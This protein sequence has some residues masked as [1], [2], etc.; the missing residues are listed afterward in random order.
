MVACCLAYIGIVENARDL[1]KKTNLPLSI[2]HYLNNMA[3]LTNQW[4]SKNYKDPD[5]QRIYLKDIDCPTL[6]HD[7]LSNII[8]PALFYL[9]ESTGDHGGPGAVEEPKP[10][11]PGIRRGRAIAHAGDL[12]SSLPP[13]M[14]AENMMC[15]IGH[16]GTYTPAHREMCASLGHNIMV[17]TSTGAMEDGKLTKPGSS[18]WFMTESKDRHV[19]SEYWLSALGHD[20]E[21]E[22]HFAQINAWK[23]APFK[24]W[25][26]EQRVGDFILIP[27]LAPHQVWNRGT[28]TMKAAWNRT[29]VETLEMALEEALPRA[30]MVCRDEQYKNKAIVYYTL[31]KYSKL[32]IAAVGLVQ[33][34]S[35]KPPVKVRQLG[36][37]FRRLHTL[38]T[39]I[40]ISESFAPGQEAMKVEL[41][42]YD[43]N[44]T[45]S[46]C[47]CNI[48]NRF[49]TCPSCIGELPNGDEDTYDICME[50][51]AMGR[52]CR[53]ISKLKWIEQFS[54]ADLT[55][56]HEQWRR[57]IVHFEGPVTEKSPKLL[58][59]ELERY[60]KRSLG[61]I[62][63]IELKK[64]PWKDIRKP[65]APADEGNESEEVVVNG[66]GMVQKKK[67]KPRQSEKFK[68][69]HK[70]CHFHTTWEP[71]WKQ[72]EC[73]Q[74]DASFCYG[75]LARAF[76]MK[77][78]EILAEKGW[79]CPK[80]CS[81]CICRKCRSK[82]GWKMI[83][84]PRTMLG[85]DTK[86]VAD[87]RSVENLV[88][89]SQSNISWLQKV[90]D[91][92]TKDTRRLQKRKLAAEKAKAQEP[93]LGD[94]YV[95]DTNM[96]GQGHDAVEDSLLRLARQEGIPIDPNL[97]NGG[98]D[99]MPSGDSQDE[100]E[101]YNENPEEASIGDIYESYHQG[102]SQPQH[103]IPA[104]GIIR[105]A[106]R[107]YDP[108]EAITFDYPDPEFEHQL[109]QSGEQAPPREQAPPGYEPAVLPEVPA[110][111]E[112]VQRKRKR[113][114]VE[115]GEEPYR[116]HK[117]IKDMGGK[118]KKERKSL[119]VRLNVDKS[120]LAELNKM[121]IIAH[122]ALNGVDDDDTPVISSDLRALNAKSGAANAQPTAKKIRPER[123]DEDD[124]FTGPRVRKDKAPVPDAHIL[125]ARRTRTH[126]VAYDEPSDGEGFEELLGG[127]GGRKSRRPQQTGLNNN[128]TQSPSNSSPNNSSNPTDREGTAASS[129]IEPNLN[130]SR[131]EKAG[132]VSVV[133]AP[134]AAQQVTLNSADGIKSFAELNEHTPGRESANSS[135]TVVS[136]I[137]VTSQ[138]HPNE[139]MPTGKSPNSSTNHRSTPSS[140]QASSIGTKQKV[141]QPQRPSASQAE[142]NR[143]A[144]L[145]AMH[146]AEG[147]SDDFEAE[148][149][150]GSEAEEGGDDD[151]DDML[152][153]VIR[154]SQPAATA[155]KSR[156]SLPGSIQTASKQ[157]PS[158][159]GKSASA[160]K[161]GPGERIH[162]VSSGEE[163]AEADSEHTRRS[164][165]SI[166]AKRV[167]NGI[168]AM[169]RRGRPRT[170]GLR[171]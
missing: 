123:E 143:K 86:K 7:K 167:V 61:E 139:Q 50:C 148:T 48:F 111:I 163:M 39:Q 104:G 131:G 16:E 99:V 87:P 153:P 144:K 80:C 103:V 46:Y 133:Q 136:T 127:Q 126:H 162:V 130:P 92:G 76:D 12:M 6:W 69:E 56:K 3:L 11:G 53:C 9:N 91:D 14:R 19:V 20:I 22:N 129:P 95:Q 35:S 135:P 58:K 27:P 109:P 97:A 114:G 145:A 157:L 36:K 147:D 30:R 152:V 2:G 34:S 5:R 90:G 150:S 113:S 68:R 8:P 128:E 154:A 60:G 106:D 75:T 25:V 54:W 160:R 156:M 105:D 82:P 124:D 24:T 57:Q 66:E 117:K 21:V 134:P 73:S 158:R 171:L 84:P 65:A 170:S 88:D 121:A 164:T 96:A 1:T 138:S 40:L 49:L 119:V 71:K 55:Q 63:Q 74:C 141:K 33:R 151:R 83:E 10:H 17:E 132:A 166:G 23:A 118:K 85:H 51:Y 18:I 28:R 42:P 161:A 70:L 110:E 59:V 155:I 81:F 38:Y 94:D 13:E 37:D 100:D 78:Q 165:S 159:G 77:P 62:C 146:W 168:K 93:R 79:K 120:K 31:V 29:T 64:R 4:T 98:G 140:T 72:I 26:V 125:P 169:A 122:R 15:Y 67:R 142:K 101:R 137:D 108:T 107:A 149:S 45:C 52:S 44:I 115:P 116:T 102:P 112:M 89:Y 32:L 41:V 47:R 43:G